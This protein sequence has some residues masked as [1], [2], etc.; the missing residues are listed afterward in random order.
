MRECEQTS[1][2]KNRLSKKSSVYSQLRLFTNRG[3]SR[4][5]VWEGHWWGVWGDGSPQWGL[6]ADPRLGFGA[7]PQKPE[8]CYDMRL[9]KT[10]TERKKQVYTD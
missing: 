5:L 7:I 3:R 10:L 4:I 9:K 2:F 8:G 6:G 1:L